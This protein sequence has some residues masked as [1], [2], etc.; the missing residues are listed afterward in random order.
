MKGTTAA[1]AAGAAGE[2]VQ[3]RK[4]GKGKGRGRGEKRSGIR[5]EVAGFAATAVVV[6]NAATAADSAAGTTTREGYDRGSGHERVELFSRIFSTHSVDTTLN[7]PNSKSSFNQARSLRCLLLT[8]SNFVN[9]EDT[10]N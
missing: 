10:L 9:H 6:S 3:G 7:N 5:R 2:R 4:G 8:A 1:G